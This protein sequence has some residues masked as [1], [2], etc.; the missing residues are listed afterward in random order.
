MSIKNH[1]HYDDYNRRYYR[2]ENGDKIPEYICLC[3]AHEPSECCC[4]CKW[5][6]LESHDDCTSWVDQDYSDQL[7]WEEHR[8]E[9]W[10]G[11]YE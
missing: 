10:G 6:L 8:E 5:D 11:N 3:A 1:F 7:E 4:D 2:D 9:T